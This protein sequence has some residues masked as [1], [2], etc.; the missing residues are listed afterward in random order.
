VRLTD[1]LGE[2]TTPDEASAAGR[3]RV[4]LEGYGHRWLRV[5]RPDE[6]RLV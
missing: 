4:E 1:L 5:L 6:K 2:R 3:H